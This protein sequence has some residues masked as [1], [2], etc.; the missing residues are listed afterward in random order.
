M[1][2]LSEQELATHFRSMK[3]GGLDGP[4]DLAPWQTSYSSPRDECTPCPSVDILADHLSHTIS[5]LEAIR[6][7]T[8]VT[9][10][11]F[12]RLSAISNAS[13]EFTQVEHDYQTALHQLRSHAFLATAPTAPVTRL[14][15]HVLALIFSYVKSALRHTSSS[16]YDIDD[17]DTDERPSQISCASVCQRWRNVAHQEPSLWNHIIYDA[18]LSSDAL[19]TW[20]RRSGSSA[21]VDLTLV[22]LPGNWRSWEQQLRFLNN[23]SGRLR[24]VVLV[25]HCRFLHYM[26]QHW[27]TPASGLKELGFEHTKGRCRY[28]TPTKGTYARAPTSDAFPVLREFKVSNAHPPLSLLS[29]VDYVQISNN[30]RELTLEFR[31]TSSDSDAIL[32]LLRS[33]PNLHVLVMSDVCFCTKVDVQDTADSIG[34]PITLAI[35]KKL[36]VSQSHAVCWR[37]LN[38]LDVPSLQRVVMYPRGWE[39]WLAQWR[40]APPAPIP[41]PPKPV[42]PLSLMGFTRRR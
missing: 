24:T 25:G 41:Q 30:L 2:T 4:L 42:H 32:K 21:S 11:V 29:A 20:L 38:L 1:S 3:E 35:L 6:N 23:I 10:G 31:R 15:E 5:T 14:P 8:P 17:Y 18:G 7:T 27:L 28:K 12:P 9:A 19:S 22:G 40:P 34:S 13:T 37:W 33:C 16:L 36:S 26:A 39:Q